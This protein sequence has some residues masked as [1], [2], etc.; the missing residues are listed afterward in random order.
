MTNEE[1]KVLVSTAAKQVFDE[2]KNDFKGAVTEAILPGVLAAKESFVTELKAEAAASSSP[3]V[4]I[5]SYGIAGIASLTYKIVE[6]VIE[7]TTAEETTTASTETENTTAEETA[8]I[9]TGTTATNSEQTVVT[10]TE[11]TVA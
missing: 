3:W 7:N 10:P 11:N 9:S 1:I 8:T 2:L 4:K 5:R 6:K